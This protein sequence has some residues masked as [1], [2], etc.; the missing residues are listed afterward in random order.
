MLSIT[1][2]V[3]K[4]LYGYARLEMLQ[5][6]DGKHIWLIDVQSAG[7]PA[8]FG[9]FLQDVRRL[10]LFH[11]AGQDIEILTR[12]F[13]RAPAPW[14]DTQIAA[15]FVGFAYPLSL[16]KLVLEIVGVK[17]SKGLTFTHWDQRPLSDQQMR[18]ASDDVRFLLAIQEGLSKRLAIRGVPLARL[19]ISIAPSI[20]MRHFKMPAERTII[21]CNSSAL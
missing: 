8:E 7:L 2:Y 19:L 18:Y 4:Q 5:I 20:S 14:F 10:K 9:A 21:I 15:G 12:L 16:A 13:G 6:S 17:L 11:A 3:L 1:L